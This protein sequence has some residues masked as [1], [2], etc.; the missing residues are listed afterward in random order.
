[1]VKDLVA[2]ENTGAAVR[3]TESSM[4]RCA[5]DARLQPVFADNVVVGLGR[6]RVDGRA[7]WCDCFTARA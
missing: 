7:P 6:D 3:E 1:M 5:I 2:V 4:R